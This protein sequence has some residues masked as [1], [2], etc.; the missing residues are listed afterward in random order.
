MLIL[1]KVT[2]TGTRGYDL[3]MALGRDIVQPR[4]HSVNALCF[5][6][7]KKE[8]FSFGNN[9]KYRENIQSGYKKIPYSLHPDSPTFC[10]VCFIVHLT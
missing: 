8:N 2:F 4:T 5:L 9:F 6:P 1:N 3:N 10:A 7:I